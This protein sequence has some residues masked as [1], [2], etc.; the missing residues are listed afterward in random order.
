MKKLIIV[1]IEMVDSESAAR[2]AR[3]GYDAIFKNGLMIA[4]REV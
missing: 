1:P 2:M 3:E 4:K